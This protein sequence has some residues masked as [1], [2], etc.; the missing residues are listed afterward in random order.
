MKTQMT[1]NRQNNLEKKQQSQRYH[2]PW[3]QTIPQ[4]STNQ[5]NMVLA[6]TNKQTKYTCKRNWTTVSHHI[7]NSTQ[8]RLKT[9]IH[10]TP[11]RKYR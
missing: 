9:E 8:N 7:Q 1:L 3:F 11:G 5:N 6:K 4:N 10:K 2:T